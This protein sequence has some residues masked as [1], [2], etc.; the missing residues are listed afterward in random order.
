[1]LKINY[2]H[3]KSLT[4][5]IVDTKKYNNKFPYLLS[6]N[7]MC[8]YIP[9]IYFKVLEMFL[10]NNWKSLQDFFVQ[11]LFDFDSIY[12]KSKCAIFC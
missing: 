3:A 10:K 2:N 12:I 8:V 7:Y 1:M 4:R 11:H 6:K 5:S 9:I